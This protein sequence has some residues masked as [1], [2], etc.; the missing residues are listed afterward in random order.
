[1]DGETTTCWGESA[2]WARES[3]AKTVVKGEGK[4][5]ELSG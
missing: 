4:D 5:E 2:E 3:T 1:M